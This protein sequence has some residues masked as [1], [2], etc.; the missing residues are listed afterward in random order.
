MEEWKRK[1]NE[2]DGERKTRTEIE[3]KKGTKMRNMLRK[4]D[5]KKKIYI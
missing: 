2:R 3:E 1:G 5:W 4:Y